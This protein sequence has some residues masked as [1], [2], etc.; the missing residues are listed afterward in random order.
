MTSASSAT[1]SSETRED[2]RPP[3]APV[4]A[5]DKDGLGARS[6]IDCEARMGLPACLKVAGSR[7][8]RAISAPGAI[9]SPKPSLTKAVVERADGI[10]IVE[11]GER[12][13]GRARG[14]RPVRAGRRSS[15]P[16]WPAASARPGPV[17]RR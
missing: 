16:R 1:V 8:G 9:D 2:Q 6:D 5:F 14:K 13:S 15:R 7:W 10:V 3:A 17:W 11:G 12:A 4:L